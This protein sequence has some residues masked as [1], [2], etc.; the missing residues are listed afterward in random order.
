MIKFR[1]YPI[2]EFDGE[3]SNIIDINSN[4]DMSIDVPDFCVISFFGDAV[5]RKITNENCLTLGA[6]VMET[7]E[8]PI[9][10]CY[11]SNGKKVA[12]MHGLGGGP[13]AAGQVEKLSALGCKKYM[14]CGGCGML[15]KGSKV[16][17]LLIPKTALRDEGTSYH[18]IPPSRTIDVNEVVLIKIIDYLKK[19]DLGFEIVKTWTTDAMYRETV[20]MVARRREEGCQVVE[21]ECASFYAVGQY[22]NIEIGQLLYAGDDLSRPKWISRDWKKRTNIRDAILDLSIEIC[23]IL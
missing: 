7:F 11:A 2:L 21:M 10:E 4:V 1:E 13:Y 20:D 22:K 17:D 18:Y 6:L 3:S 19:H 12:L 9:Y 8:L 16:G 23:S 14:V 5:K 15:T